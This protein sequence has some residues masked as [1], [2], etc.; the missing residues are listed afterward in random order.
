MSLK[1]LLQF[2]CQA[3]VTVRDEGGDQAGQSGHDVGGG[4]GEASPHAFDGEED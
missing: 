3:G 4:E 1:S 2:R